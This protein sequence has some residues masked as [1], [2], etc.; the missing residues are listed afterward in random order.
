MK[1][2]FISYNKNDKKKA[3]WI[4]WILEE[5]G[6][7]TIIQAWDFLPGQ[8]FVLK[9]QHASTSC[10]KTLAVLSKHYLGAI[11]TQS[12]WASAFAMDPEGEERKLLLVKVS[13]C[14]PTGI[15][16]PMIFCDLVG[17]NE[18]NAKRTLLTSVDNKRRKPTERCKFT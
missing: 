4:A 5:A 8:N 18:S 12:E 7:T 9:M 6:Y 1:D 3:E 10:R 17:L 15:L 16:R 14:E 13:E 2:F 11:Y